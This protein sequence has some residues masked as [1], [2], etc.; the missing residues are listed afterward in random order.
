M[1]VSWCSN[2]KRLKQ[3]LRVTLIKSHKLKQHLK[4]KTIGCQWG[5][6][7]IICDFTHKQV[8]F[9]KSDVIHEDEFNTS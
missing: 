6:D 4:N 5:I 3:S 8:S 1:R 9:N 7:D 2:R